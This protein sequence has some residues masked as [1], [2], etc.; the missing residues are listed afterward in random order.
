MQQDE[1]LWVVDKDDT[2]VGK[3]LRSETYGDGRN[4][5]RVINAF[6]VHTDGRIWIPTRAPNKRMFPNALDMS[7]GG[8]VEYGESYEEAFLRETMEELN[9]DLN[10]T[11]WKVL[12]KL[13][14]HEHDVSAFMTVYA[15]YSEETPQYNPDDF[16][17]AEWV[18]P[19]EA[20]ATIASG[21]PAKGDL[22]KLLRFFISL[23]K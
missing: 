23:R 5:F 13:N 10:V 11:P 14:P 8:H 7:V 20:L 18:T 9:I 22:A 4:D 21:V 19:E 15:I 1:W 17:S 6:L 12:G 2:P 3:V 16:V